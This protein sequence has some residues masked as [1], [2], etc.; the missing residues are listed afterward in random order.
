MQKIIKR[1]VSLPNK[2]RF[3]C[4]KGWKGHLLQRC[5]CVFVKGEHVSYMLQGRTIKTDI[6]ANNLHTTSFDQHSRDGAR[7]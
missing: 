3:I 6:M 7:Q 1:K 2:D 4:Y 5:G